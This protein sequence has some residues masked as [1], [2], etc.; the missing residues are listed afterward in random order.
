MH[1]PDLTTVPAP[2]L[3]PAGA[4]S[5]RAASGSGLEAIFRP[6]SIAVIGASRDRATVGGELFHNLVKHDFQGAVYPVNPKSAV[7]QSVKAYPTIEAVPE[8]VDLALIV[9]PGA[10][11]NATLEA[12][13]QKG[14]RGAVVISAGFK[15][16]GGEGVE[17]EREMVAIARKYGMRVV[18]PNCLG[19]LNTEPGVSMDATFAPPFPPPGPRGVLVAER[20]AGAGDPRVRDGAQR[21]PLALRQ[22]RQQGRRLGQRP[23]RVLGARPRHAR[24]PALPGIVR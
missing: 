16:I 20:R 4:S 1:D 23:A 5:P 15:E 11:V 12:C 8:E 10:H 14:V 3:P 13:G 22:R 21:R 9:V 6:R 18:G 19:V 7:V 17:R 24:H 2:A